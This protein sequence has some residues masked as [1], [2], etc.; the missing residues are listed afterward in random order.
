MMFANV[1]NSTD[2]NLI[3]SFFRFICNP[4]CQ[5]IR[6]KKLFPISS[7]TTD[8][9]D[10]PLFTSADVLTANVLT[11]HN[12]ATLLTFILHS[13]LLGSCFPDFVVKI[14]NVS[15]SQTEGIPGSKLLINA[16]FH[17]TKINPEIL[18]CPYCDQPAMCGWSKKYNAMPVN[19]KRIQTPYIVFHLDEQ[20]RAYKMEFTIYETYVPASATTTMPIVPPTIKNIV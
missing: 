14:S 2:C 10:T 17:G 13:F 12:E 4:D 19:V 11:L 16:E 7:L 18:I 15:I 9:T 1:H 3:D 20:H 6:C 8:I 5:I